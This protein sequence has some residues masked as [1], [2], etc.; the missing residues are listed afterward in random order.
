MF[1]IRFIMDI[2]TTGAVNSRHEP[3]RTPAH[4]PSPGLAVNALAPVAAAT[5]LGSGVLAGVFFGFSTLVMPSLRR[6]P[7]PEAVTAMQAI[8]DVAPRSLLMLPLVTSGAGSLA[9]AAWALADADTAGRGWLL[10]GAGAG[11]A[12]FLITAAYHVPRNNALATGLRPRQGR[13]TSGSGTCASG[14]R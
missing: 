5:A 8:N 12:C 2:V 6:L 3:H 13:P 4:H 10:A 7:V 1:V 9:V 14:R 11:V